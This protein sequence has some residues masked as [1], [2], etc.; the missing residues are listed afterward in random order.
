V[1]DG[2][3]A[4]TGLVADLRSGAPSSAPQELTAIGNVL[5]FAA[6]DGEHG[7]EPWRS[8]GTAA[9]TRR[10][11]DISPGRDASSP[12]PFSLVGSNVLTG[13]DDG[14]HGRE[15]WAIP[16]QDVVP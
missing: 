1:S 4:S 10:L 5:V 13:A 14:V 7:V 16:V 8:D 9:G 3:S 11:G 12:G 2:S 6:D 15:L